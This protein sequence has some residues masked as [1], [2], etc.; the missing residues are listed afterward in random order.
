MEL[1]AALDDVIGSPLDPPPAPTL[2]VD[3]QHWLRRFPVFTQTLMPLIKSLQATPPF[4]SLSARF[5]VRAALSLEAE[6]PQVRAL[7]H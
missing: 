4:K 5:P 2:M 1:A 3:P 6:M 7:V